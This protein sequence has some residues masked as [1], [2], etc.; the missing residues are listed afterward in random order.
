M[1]IKNKIISF[2]GDSL[3]EGHGVADLNN[4]YDN[5][6][7]CKGELKEVCNYGIGGTRLAYQKQASES[8]RHDL[9]F[10]GRAGGINPE[11]DIIVVMGGTN[12]YGHGQAPFGT[13][14]DCMPDTYCGAVEYLMN[15]LRDAFPN[16]LKVFMTPPR[17]DGDLFADS[18]HVK[19]DDAKPL[20][21]YVDV[22]KC[23]AQEHNFPVL[24]LYEVL[25]INPNNEQ[26]KFKYA[27]D[28]LHL[29]DEGH[30]ILADCLLDFLK[31]L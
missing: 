2:L 26:D 31:K 15:Y 23:K 5:V 8:P 7:L 13:M 20:K 21:E 22:I 28:G 27:P 19:L 11:S 4:R 9:C 25:G 30:K 18:N 24:D 12:D 3:T 29:N 1:E 6:L 10:C 16:A 17:R 14:T